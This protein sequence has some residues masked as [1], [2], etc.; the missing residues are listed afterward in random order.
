MTR[1]SQ[2]SLSL[3]PPAIQYFYFFSVREINYFKQLISKIVFI[4][5]QNEICTNF[6]HVYFAILSINITRLT[7]RKP[8][9]DVF[10]F[11][12]VGFICSTS[13]LLLL[14]EINSK[15]KDQRIL[16]LNITN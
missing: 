12:F 10:V 4:V 6:V 16:K 9:C 11:Q 13:T 7:H 2:I 15:Q 8:I 1:T 3:F 5:K 14:F